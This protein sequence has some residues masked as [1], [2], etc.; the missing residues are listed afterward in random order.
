[1]W[2][3]SLVNLTLDYQGRVVDRLIKMKESSESINVSWAG[4]EQQVLY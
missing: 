2:S 1:M 3:C 4:L